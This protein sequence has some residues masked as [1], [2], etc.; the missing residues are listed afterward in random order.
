M[1]SKQD[2]NKGWE[3]VDGV[4]YSQYL[5]Y[6]PEF[7][8]IKL[9]GQHHV[10]PLAGHFKIKKTW[11]LIA[12]KYYQPI[13]QANVELYIKSCNICLASKA[14]CHKPYSD[15]QFLPILTHQQK[16]LS[17][18]FVMR[19]LV[20]TNQKGKTF[21]FILVIINLLEKMV[22]YKPVKITI[23]NPGLAKFVIKVV[24]H[25]HCLLNSIVRHR[26]S[27]FIP[28]FWSLLYYFLR[29]NSN[30]STTFHTHTDSQT[31]KEISIIEAYVRAFDY[32]KQN[33]WA[34]L[35]TMAKY[36]YN[37]TKNVSTGNTSFELNCGYY[38]FISYKE[39]FDLGSKSKS[40]D[41][42]AAKLR[43]HMTV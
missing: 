37:N 39:D 33:D 43:D 7:I 24:V 1:R 26:G 32:Y 13:L 30:L 27:V 19:L 2:L 11:K 42:L 8:R 34:R 29:I 20:L 12:K 21:D 9:I 6:V 10:N 31:E 35:L 5:P 40:A 22:H 28:Q 23:N 14:V 17:M 38:L 4:L 18:D 36:V 3:E 15:L 16:V 25:Y 41:E